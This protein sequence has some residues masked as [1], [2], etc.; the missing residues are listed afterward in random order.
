MSGNV[1]CN[2]EWRDI[3][4]EIEKGELDNPKNYMTKEQWKK[5]QKGILFDKE[6]ED[7]EEELHEETTNKSSLDDLVDSIIELGKEINKK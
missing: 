3:Y 1:Y 7:C 6:C 4:M 5:A 2:G